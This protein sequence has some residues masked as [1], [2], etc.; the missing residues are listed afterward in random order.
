MDLGSLL[1]SL[2]LAI[3]ANFFA[4]FFSAKIFLKQK[5]RHLLNLVQD[6]DAPVGHGQLGERVLDRQSGE[7]A[8]D[9]PERRLRDVLLPLLV[10]R[11]DHHRQHD[12]RSVALKIKKILANAEDICYGM[13]Q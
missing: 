3:F 10:V 9:E 11:L 2:I 1:G 7:G 13:K 8:Q 6:G 5:D 12:G 4:I